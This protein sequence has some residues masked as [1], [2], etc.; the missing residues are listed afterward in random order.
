MV[1]GDFAHGDVAESALGGKEAG[2]AVEDAAHVFVGGDEALHEDVGLAFG[3]TLH[4]HGHAFGVAFAVD[5]GEER[6]VDAQVGA[7]A[8][9]LVLGAEENGGDEPGA[10]GVVDGGEGVGVAGVGHGQAFAAAGDG[11]VKNLLKF[12]YHGSVFF[13]EQGAF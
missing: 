1:A 10:D 5:E 3:H 2:V 12:G 6:G 8:A 4:G 9:C 11:L 7:E 13:A